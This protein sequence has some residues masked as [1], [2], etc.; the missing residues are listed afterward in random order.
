MKQ[1]FIFDGIR[2]PFGKYGGSLSSIR[3]DDLMAI[4]I[5]ELILKYPTIND[6]IED[7]IIGDSNQAGEDAR[8]VA[9]NSALLSG[10]S[11]NTAGITVN[12]LC[13]S[14]LAAVH[15]GSNSIK[16]NEGSLYIAGGIESMTRAPLILLKN[17]K[18]FLRSLEYA[19]STI[20]WRFPNNSLLREIGQDSM[21]ETSDNIAKKLNISREESDLFAFQ[22]QMKHEKAFNAGF[23]EH[24]IFPIKIHSSN[25]RDLDYNMTKDEHPRPKSTLEDLSKLKPLNNKGVTTAGNSSGVNDGAAAVL[26]GSLDMIEKLDKYP[27]AEII[28]TAVSGVEPRLMGLGPVSAIQK[29]LKKAGLSLKDIDVIEINEAFSTQVL[30][31][32][33]LLEVPFDD[34]RINPNGG[35]IA[36]GHPLGASGARLILTASRELQNRGGKYALVSLCIGIGQGIATIIKNPNIN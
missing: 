4:T 19:D 35:A 5:R 33:K 31:C 23:F 12:R 9:R 21:P 27:I 18:P 30:G 29:V 16:C 25:K 11:I 2:T 20:G 17:D 7:V 34:K 26:L 8:N 28:T 6:D 32:L 36:I 13:G 14:G 22:S 3:P 10:L 1:A 24:E 15:L